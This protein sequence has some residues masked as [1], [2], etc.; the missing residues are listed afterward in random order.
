MNHYILK[1]FSVVK[2]DEVALFKVQKFKAKAD[3][4]TCPVLNWLN[5]LN[6]NGVNDRPV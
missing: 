2:R 6:W 5:D 4:S 1:L 3:P